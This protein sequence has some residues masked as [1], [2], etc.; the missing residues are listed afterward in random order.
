MASINFLDNFNLHKKTAKHLI[1]IVTLQQEKESKK[2]N[3]QEQEA[4]HNS[5]ALLN[6]CGKVFGGGG[7]YIDG[8]ETR[9]KELRK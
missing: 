9:S 4:R 7:F 5:H 3:K 2:C 6:Q 8:Q 1:A